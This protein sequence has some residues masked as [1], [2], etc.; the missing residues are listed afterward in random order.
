MKIIFFLAFFVT[1]GISLPV[2]TDTLSS[3]I[4]IGSGARTPLRSCKEIEDSKKISW[5]EG[6]GQITPAGLRQMYLLGRYLRKLYIEDSNFL[7]KIFEPSKIL[8]RSVK[9]ERNLMA[10]QSFSLGLYPSGATLLS[11]DDLKNN[12]LWAPPFELTIPSYVIEDLGNSSL[13]FDIPLVPVITYDSSSEKL[14]SFAECPKYKQEWDK[15]FQSEKIKSFFNKHDKTLKTLIE[16]YNIALENLEEG[17]NIHYFLDYIA[18]AGFQNKIPEENVKSMQYE[19]YEQFFPEVKHIVLCNFSEVAKE[20]FERAR[21]N[22]S[23][24]AKMLVLATDELNV[25]GYLFAGQFIEGKNFDIGLSVEIRMLKKNDA[26][27]VLILLNGEKVKELDYENFIKNIE[28]E[29][30]CWKKL[31]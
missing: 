1:L 19:M 8:I 5:P 29:E 28:S 26:Y 14:L 23:N 25:L 4:F 20:H 21:N 11:D 6:Y 10:A 30:D 17:D 2:D 27:K 3:I 12:S 7:N 24:G 22:T 15:Y 13:P 18:A 31:C 16:K 9:Q